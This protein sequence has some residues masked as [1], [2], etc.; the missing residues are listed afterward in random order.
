MQTYPQ[1][2]VVKWLTLLFHV[3]E[4]LGSNLYLVTGYPDWGFYGLPQ[5]LQAKARSY[6]KP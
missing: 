5:S 6:L 3:W 2:I 1:N 4:V